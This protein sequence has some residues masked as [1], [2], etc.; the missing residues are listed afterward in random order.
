M[1][2]GPLKSGIP[3]SVEI[4]APLKTRI[5]LLPARTAFA[6]SKSLTSDTSQCSSF[7]FSQT[8]EGETS[9]LCRRL[10]MKRLRLSAKLALA[11]I[12]IGLVALIAA[13]F[14]ALTFLSDSREQNETAHAAT[15]AADAI[16]TLKAVWDEEGQARQVYLFDN[17]DSTDDLAS[18]IDR[19]D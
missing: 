16:E 2:S 11:I 5:L 1:P 10:S 8:I 19:T 13:G 9:A 17:A 15:V 7:P 4:P 12:P 14:I 3:D 6:S 18:A